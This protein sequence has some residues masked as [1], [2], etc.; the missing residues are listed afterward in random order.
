M[1]HASQILSETPTARM[2]GGIPIEPYLEIAKLSNSTM[3]AWR[4]DQREFS[5]RFVRRVKGPPPSDVMKLG[6]YF[7][8]LLCG[9]PNVHDDFIIAPAR[10]EDPE[11]TIDRR[12]KGGKALWAEFMSAAGRRDIILP[13]QAIIAQQMLESVADHPV[14]GPLFLRGI[15]IDQPVLVWTCPH[16]GLPMKARLD[17]AFPDENIV[18]ELKTDQDPRPSR[19]TENRWHGWGYHRKLAQYHDGW[20]EVHK[21]RP[22]IL[23]V[24]VANTARP[25]TVVYRYLPDSPA[26]DVGRFEYIETA[27]EIGDALKSGEY[28]YQWETEIIEGTVPAWA[29]RSAAAG[30]TRAEDASVLR[31]LEGIETA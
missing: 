21:V 17:R 23:L 14:A 5:D 22:T 30:E 28:R 18:V 31:R 26:L 19:A 6:K 27:L 12:K 2:I 1:S 11:K 3:E 25:R 7:E 29:E 9:D 8:A 16:T 15:G 24:A 20:L 10:P 4:R 13:G